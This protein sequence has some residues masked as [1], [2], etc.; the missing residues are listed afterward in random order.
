MYGRMFFSIPGLYPPDV[1]SVPPPDIA[2]VPLGTP[3]P[4]LYMKGAFLTQSQFFCPLFLLLDLKRKW[5]RQKGQ[6]S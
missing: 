5:E 1:S 6:V 3:S 2:N 4:P